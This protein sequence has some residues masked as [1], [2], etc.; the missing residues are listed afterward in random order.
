MIDK[1]CS[2]YDG[3]DRDDEANLKRHYKELRFNNENKDS[4]KEPN[5]VLHETNVILLPPK[6]EC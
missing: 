1:F 2:I 4:N 3:L 5:W 6:K